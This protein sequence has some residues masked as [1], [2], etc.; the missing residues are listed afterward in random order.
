MTFS[1]PE[2][3]ADVDISEARTPTEMHEHFVS[4]NVNDAKVVA[5]NADVS[6]TTKVASEKGDCL[7]GSV[8][9]EPSK[10]KPHQ[11]PSFSVKNERAPVKEEKTATRQEAAGATNLA[12]GSTKVDICK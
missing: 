10:T 4:T 7:G 1:C 8:Q 11:E 5:T 6:L 3:A 2:R 9:E 12:K